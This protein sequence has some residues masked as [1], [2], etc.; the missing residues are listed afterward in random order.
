MCHLLIII[1]STLYLIPVHITQFAALLDHVNK[2]GIICIY[3]IFILYNIYNI[4]T[5]FMHMD[6]RTWSMQPNYHNMYQTPY[7]LHLNIDQYLY[8]YCILTAIIKHKESKDSRVCCW[9]EVLFNSSSLSPVTVTVTPYQAPAEGRSVN[10]TVWVSSDSC[11]VPL[12]Q[13]LWSLSRQA[14]ADVVTLSQSGPV[15]VKVNCSVL[16]SQGLSSWSRSVT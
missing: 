11:I 7:S 16:V 8:W 10:V 14:V 4:Y 6:M 2:I 5:I 15:R 9:L 13:S 3:T 12:V 1:C